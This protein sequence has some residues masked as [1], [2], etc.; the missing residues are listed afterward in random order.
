MS[1]EVGECKPA[2][3]LH[4][5]T[6]ASGSVLRPSAPVVTTASRLASP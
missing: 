2:V 3:N 1:S 6:I 4:R 5:P